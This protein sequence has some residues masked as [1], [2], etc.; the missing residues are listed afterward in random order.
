MVCLFLYLFSL[1]SV[2]SLE[3]KRLELSAPK[4]VYITVHGRRSLCIVDPA[5]KRLKVKVTHLSSVMSE[6]VCMSLWL[7]KFGSFY[8]VTQKEWGFSTNSVFGCEGENISIHRDLWSTNAMNT[9]N[10]LLGI[11]L[12][13]VHR[14]HLRPL[15]H[16]KLI[17]K[18]M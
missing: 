12:W 8:V 13:L 17:S 6:W 16:W 15:S 5:V 9:S 3:G 18:F 4:L 2:R 10:G 7:L 1:S 11:N 14:T